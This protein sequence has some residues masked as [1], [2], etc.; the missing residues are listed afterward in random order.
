MQLL[1]SGSPIVSL[2]QNHLL[3]RLLFGQVRGLTVL[4]VT[5]LTCWEL[6]LNFCTLLFEKQIEGKILSQL[7]GIWAACILPT[8]LY[9]CIYVSMHVCINIHTHTHTYKSI[10]LRVHTHT[11]THIRVCAHLYIYSICSI[12][13]DCCTLLSYS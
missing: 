11:H 9:T 8:R 6:P 13:P 7:S 5:P 3:L 1:L 4:R 2:M 12:W 10:S